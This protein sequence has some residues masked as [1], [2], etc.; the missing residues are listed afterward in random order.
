VKTTH[1]NEIRKPYIYIYYEQ[2]CRR[3]RILNEPN[4]SVS[5]PSPETLIRSYIFTDF[6]DSL[7]RDRVENY[8]PSSDKNLRIEKKRKTDSRTANT[9][10]TR[11]ILSRYTVGVYQKPAMERRNIIRTILRADG[12]LIEVY[13]FLNTGTIFLLYFPIIRK[14]LSKIKPFTYPTVDGFR[15]QF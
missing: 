1:S 10:E 7:P 9:L 8:V 15:F 6:S 5:P 14:Q 3:N 2:V 11:D 13:F 4:H 12:R